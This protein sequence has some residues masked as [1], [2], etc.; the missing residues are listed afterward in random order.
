MNVLKHTKAIWGNTLFL[1]SMECLD[2]Y[3]FP[4]HDWGSVICETQPSRPNSLQPPWKVFDI[5]CCPQ[6]MK[7]FEIPAVW[8][9]FSKCSFEIAAIASCYTIVS[10]T[11]IIKWVFLSVQPLESPEEPVF[12][13]RDINVLVSMLEVANKKHYTYVYIHTYIYIYIWI[14]MFI[15][16]SIVV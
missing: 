6:S 10:W 4:I 5:P 11:L 1:G 12:I 9:I 8:S 15:P 3:C 14:W 7:P 16:T 13:L 2:I